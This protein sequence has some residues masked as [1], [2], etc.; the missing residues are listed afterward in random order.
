[1]NLFTFLAVQIALVMAGPMF[2][3]KQHLNETTARVHPATGLE[4][5]ITTGS[6]NGIKRGLPRIEPDESTL[7]V[8]EALAARQDPNM[9]PTIIIDALAEDAC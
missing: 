5:G 3:H 9:I 2:I 7:A 8:P 6:C 1:M 4:T